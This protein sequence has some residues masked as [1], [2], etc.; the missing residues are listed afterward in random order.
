[1]LIN[2]K[3]RDNS[4]ISQTPNIS[5]CLLQPIPKIPNYLFRRLAKIVTVR[6]LIERFQSLHQ[7]FRL[8]RH[9]KCEWGE[10]LGEFPPVSGILNAIAIHAGVHQTGTAGCENL[11]SRIGTIPDRCVFAVVGGVF[12]FA[13]DLA[14]DDDDVAEVLF[15]SGWVVICSDAADEGLD[16]LYEAF[17]LIFDKRLRL[18]V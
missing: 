18:L 5:S 9:V 2:V 11:H 14:N 16:R 6:I 12:G 8:P 3:I 7:L 1:M 13:D 15:N 4:F 10:Q 17:R